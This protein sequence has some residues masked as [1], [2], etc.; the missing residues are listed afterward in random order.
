MKKYILFIVL[1]VVLSGSGCYKDKGLP[2]ADFS[3]KEDIDSKVPDTVTF[4]NLSQNAS[5]YE[6]KF[7][8]GTTS[9]NDNPVHIYKDT[10][11]YDVK[12]TSYSK[13][14]KDWSIADKTIH[15]K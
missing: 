2:T 6:W 10:G 14:E 11:A 7:G 8:D 5:S 3:Y 4:T 1:V 13:G 15:V 9:S 12:L